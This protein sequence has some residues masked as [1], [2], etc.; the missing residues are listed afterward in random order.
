MCDVTESVAFERLDSTKVINI[1]FIN[2]YLLFI[3]FIHKRNAKYPIKII[4]LSFLMKRK[5]LLLLC[6]FE[7]SLHGIL[8]KTMS[9]VITQFDEKYKYLPN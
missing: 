8:S 5:Y 2:I 7:I 1:N 3:L 9:N 4:I 6:R